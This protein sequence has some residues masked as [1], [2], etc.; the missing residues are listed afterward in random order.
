MR[1]LVTG[2][3][4]FVGSHVA[5][6]ACARGDAVR[7]LVRAGSDRAPLRD[8][9]AEIAVGDLADR[10]SLA[11]AAAG[12]DAIVHCAATTSETSPDLAA[13]RRTNVVG[14]RNLLEAAAAGGAPRVVFISSQSATPRNTG[15]YGRT[16][17]EAEQ[18]VAASGLPWTTLRPSTVYGPG[19]R[20]LFAKIARLVETLPIV[21]IVGDGRQRFRPIHVDDLAAA[22]LACLEAPATVGRTYDLGGLDGVSFAAFIDGVGELLGRRRAMLRLP[23]PLC[24][25]LARVLALVAKNP[26]LT[27]DNIVGLR[28]MSECDIAPAQ[29]DFGFSPRRFA[30]GIAAMRRQRAAGGDGRGTEERAV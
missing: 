6:L 19:A 5:R 2:A 21:P 14:T 30:D 27:I 15:A 16:K 1:V 9:E 23:I 24:V 22:I 13:S 20:G 18:V 17:L 3:S 29:A 11:A 26:P 25:G 7:C 4:G 28:Q 8:L 12:V 10:A